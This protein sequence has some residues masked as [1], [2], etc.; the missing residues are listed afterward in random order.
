[1]SGGQIAVQWFKSYLS[2]R[3]QLVNIGNTSSEF[4]TVSCGVLQ[5]FILGPLLFIIYVNDMKVATK[6][7]FLLYADDF[8]L[9]ISRRDV[10]KVVDS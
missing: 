3:E 9:L 6:G 1:M 8:T 2:G 10:S 5:G 7:K 4:R